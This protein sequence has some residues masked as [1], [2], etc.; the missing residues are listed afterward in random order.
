VAEPTGITGSAM[1]LTRLALRP[2]KAMGS[3]ALDRA[4]ASSLVDAL[5]K[6]IADHD[7]VE[8]LATPIARSG[9]VER[10]VGDAL[11]SQVTEELAGRAIDSALMD[12]IVERLLASEDLWILVDEIAA[13][14]AVTAAISRQ[15]M[16]LADQFAGVVRERSTRA[17]DRIE[18][19]LR[20][21]LHRDGNAPT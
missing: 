18:R 19:S 17:D 5:G 2:A 8:R 13:S 3:Y 14:P 15:G 21:L 16:G 9:A 10:L 20:R 12:Q 1:A 7:V 6:A 11:Q 4:L